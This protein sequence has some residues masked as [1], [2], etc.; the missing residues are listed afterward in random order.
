MSLRVAVDWPPFS[1]APRARSRPGFP[2]EGGRCPAGTPRAVRRYGRGREGPRPS[3][4]DRAGAARARG[5]RGV[6]RRTGP[7]AFSRGHGDAPGRSAARGEAGAVAAGLPAARLQRRAG[8]A[9]G[10]VASDLIGPSCSMGRRPGP[11]RRATRPARITA[12]M[13]DLEAALRPRC[14]GTQ[15]A[16]GR[17]RAAGWVPGLG[18][19]SFAAHWPVSPSC[20]VMRRR[21]FGGFRTWPRSCLICSC[22]AAPI[23]RCVW[24]CALC[25]VPCAWPRPMR[26]V[27]PLP[28]A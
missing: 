17:P 23:L 3:G 5:L 15:D 9:R 27:A 1:R 21:M 28:A 19:Q 6:P 16:A 26:L 4:G 20:L 13:P 25:P 24:P 18:A 7:S 14:R 8:A 12:P 10:P 22:G 11:R 2:V